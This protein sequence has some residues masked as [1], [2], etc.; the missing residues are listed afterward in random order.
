MNSRVDV[1][2]DPASIALEEADGDDLGHG[3]VPCL[4]VTGDHGQRAVPAAFEPVAGFGREQLDPAPV[5]D[6]HD[7]FEAMRRYE[8]T[9]R[10]Q[11]GVRPAPPPSDAGL[12]AA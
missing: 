9:D 5:Q 10:R 8:L 12:N 7:V 4:I 3:V 1:P 11:E 6:L 2:P